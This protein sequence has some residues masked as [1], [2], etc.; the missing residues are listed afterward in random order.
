MRHVFEHREE[1]RGTGER[2]RA[3][4]LSHW[5]WDHVVSAIRERLQDLESSLSRRGPGAIAVSE[6][7]A[8]AETEPDEALAAYKRGKAHR[9]AGRVEEAEADLK[10]AL[11]LLRDWQAVEL[12]GWVDDAYLTMAELLLEGGRFSEAA[13]YARSAIQTGS[14]EAHGTF[15]EALLRLGL[16][17]TAERATELG[18]TQPRSESR[19]T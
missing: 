13:R 19:V 18:G 2:A 6:P 10:R 5:T 8:G 17:R 16:H 4:V 14:A 7:P 3:D 9:E 12:P 1:A 15:A 11:L